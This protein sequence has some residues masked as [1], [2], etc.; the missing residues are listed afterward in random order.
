MRIVLIDLGYSAHLGVLGKPLLQKVQPAAD[1]VVMERLHARRVAEVHGR[2]VEPLD[3]EAAEAAGRL[4][5]HDRVAAQKSGERPFVRLPQ[6][7]IFTPEEWAERPAEQ[8]LVPEDFGVLR[9]VHKTAE[10]PVVAHGEEGLPVAVAADMD[11]A[12]DMVIE[13]A[14]VVQQDAQEHV[15]HD[16]QARHFCFLFDLAHIDEHAAEAEAAN[17]SKKQ[18]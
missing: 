4:H 6:I 1:P 12:E 13:K 3:L 14:D 8:D 15:E 18:A 2:R 5:E 9:P 11:E 7:Q 10:A 16:E 17:P